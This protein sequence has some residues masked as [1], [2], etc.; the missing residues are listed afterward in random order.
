MGDSPACAD[1]LIGVLSY[2]RLK[3]S[4][5]VLAEEFRRFPY[6][7]IGVMLPASTAAF[8]VVF[9]IQLAGKT[10]VMLNWTL[11]SRNLD[12]MSKLSG[13]GTVITSWSFWRGSLMS[14][15]AAWP[16]TF[17]LLEDIREK[18]S[19]GTKLRRALAVAI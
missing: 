7:Y 13:V 5:L 18:I 6:E 19:L 17:E 12:G 3:L 11:G 4:V 9:A 2:K 10:P 16:I 8:I 14:I 15:S 1:D